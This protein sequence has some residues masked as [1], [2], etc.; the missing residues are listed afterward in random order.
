M[1]D[2]ISPIQ[3][4]AI[5]MS[6]AEAAEIRNI[7]ENASWM[8]RSMHLAVEIRRQLR[9]RNMTQKQ[10][11]DLMG[12]TP[13]QI[14]KILGGRENLG[15]KT[16]CKIEDALGCELISV[17]GNQTIS[18]LDIA[19]VQVGEPDSQYVISVKNKT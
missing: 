6:D 17:A 15:L 9:R 2:K 3:R 1:T 12:V 14:T 19:P 13:A 10:L 11:A 18:Y 4:I 16:I 8:R 5:P 7:A